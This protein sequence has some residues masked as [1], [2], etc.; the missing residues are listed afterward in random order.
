[1]K[2]GLVGLGKMGYQL[3]LNMKSHQIE[4]VATDVSASQREKIALEG[5]TTAVSVEA[6][7]EALPRP[8]TIWL[9]VP[10]GAI[11][12]SI[13]TRLTTLLDPEDVVIDGGNS[14]YLDTVRRHDE[15]ARKSIRLVDCGTSGGVSG[16][17]N[18][19][20]LMVGGDA[21]VV[22]R[23]ASLF[24]A[25]A[26]EGG[27]GYVGPAGSGHFVKMVHNGIEYG[28]MQA[29]GEGFELLKAG[30]YDIDFGSLASVWS[31]GSIIEGLLLKNVRDAFAKDAGLD[32]IEGRVDDSGEGRWMVEEA[33]RKNVA[34]PVIAASLF[35][36]YKSKDEGKFAEKVV[37][38]MRNEFGGHS[39]YKKP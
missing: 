9:M 16:A 4:V 32:R 21:A 1:M 10:S 29:I 22:E 20:C 36:R 8:R 6:L 37:A 33:L 35:A 28:M 23:L 27:Y 19:A 26:R 5:V 39:V 12:E 34:V 15:L 14:M 3:A 38:A 30:P 2:I 25:I 17:R 18:G 24:T 11:V 31:N 13:V 7:I